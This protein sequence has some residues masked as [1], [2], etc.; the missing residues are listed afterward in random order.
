MC[1]RAQLKC[2]IQVFRTNLRCRSLNG[3][4][5]SRH[6]RRS[7]PPNRSQNELAFGALTGVFNTC[8]PSQAGDFFIEFLGKD[9]VTIVNN[10]S[11]SMFV[12]QSFAELL[13]GP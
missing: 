6:S 5:K 8:T 10:E 13:H 12:R 3:I 11:I 7:V 1:G 4:R 2:G 9:A